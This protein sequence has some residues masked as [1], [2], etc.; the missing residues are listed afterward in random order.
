MPDEYIAVLVP[1]ALFLMIFG[2]VAVSVWGGVAKRR[3][4]NDL[5]RRAIDA[6]H[7]LDPETLAAMERPVRSADDDVRSGITLTALA[8]GL[9]ACFGLFASGLAPGG[10]SSGFGFAIAGIIVGSIGIGRL[11]AGLARRKPTDANASGVK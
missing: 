4:T 11:V 2:I 3:D 9:A 8:F 10:T 7:K 6:G 5:L 1:G